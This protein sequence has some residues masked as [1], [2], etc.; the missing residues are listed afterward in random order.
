VLTRTTINGVSKRV[1]IVYENSDQT[2]YNTT[3]PG[4]SPSTFSIK[5]EK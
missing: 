2:T 3:L 4:L 5:V 1:F